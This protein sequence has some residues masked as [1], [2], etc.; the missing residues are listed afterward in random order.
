M[1]CRT[2][3]ALSHA[4]VPKADGWRPTSIDSIDSEVVDARCHWEDEDDA[5]MCVVV[6]EAVEDAWAVQVD[7]LGFVPPMP[8]DDGIL[9][10]YLSSHGTGGGAY[11]YGPS[12]DEDTTDGRMGC[13]SYIALSPMIGET[14][15]PSYVAHEFQHVLQYATDFVEPT[16]AIW[17]GVATAAQEWTYPDEQAGNYETPDFQAYPWAG[18]LNDSYALY[19]D[20][21]VWS[22]YEYGAVIW[23]QH[24]E[25]FYGDGLGSSGVQLWAEATQ[26]GWD[27]EPD[28]IDAYDAVTGDWIFALMDLSVERAKLGTVHASDWIENREA[29]M[30]QVEIDTA[31]DATELPITLDPTTAPYQTGVVYVQ[32]SGF[33]AG[34]WLGASISASS[35]VQWGIVFVEGSDSDWA[36]GTSYSWLAGGDDITVGIVNLGPSDFDGDDQLK[37]SSFSL[38]LGVGEAPDTGAGAGGGAGAGDSASADQKTG[39]GCATAAPRSGGLLGLLG[40]VFWARRRSTSD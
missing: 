8:D 20:H 25:A 28:V 31:L 2:A 15:M 1:I 35:Q 9:D 14:I 32:V 17:E 4:L 36:E 10:L 40:F 19:D 37:Q 23:I 30:Y 6:L 12:S 18:L 5:D 33:G 11:T 16:Y 3:L 24:L 22:Y 34:E 29:P 39:C 27:N 13:H 38:T 26:T 21:D 7:E